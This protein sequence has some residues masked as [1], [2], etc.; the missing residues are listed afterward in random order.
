M[1]FYEKDQ[2]NFPNSSDLLLENLKQSPSND[3]L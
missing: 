2:K 1:Y 3:T